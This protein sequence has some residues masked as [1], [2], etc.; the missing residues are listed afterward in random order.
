MPPLS[1]VATDPLSVG[2]VIK[3]RF[4][5]YELHE[6]I[7]KGGSGYV[8]RGVDCNTQMPV[9]V[10]VI[11]TTTQTVSTSSSGSNP[12]H[13]AKGGKMSKTIEKDC[14]EVCNGDES[15][16]LN[17][18]S[19]QLPGVSEVEALLRLQTDP[20][21]C[22]HI[23]QYLDHVSSTT[24][25]RRRVT[26]LGTGRS[27]GSSGRDRS[28]SDEIENNMDDGGKSGSRRNEAKDRRGSRGTIYTVSTTTFMI[29]EE[30]AAR[31]SL[32]KQLRLLQTMSGSSGITGNRLLCLRERDASRILYDV[33]RAL[34]YIHR[35]GILHRDIKA[36]NVLLCEDGTVKLSDFGLAIMTI[37]TPSSSGTTPTAS[38]HGDGQRSSTE[39]DRGGMRQ[40]SPTGTDT[41]EQS[42][43]VGG[44]G[45]GSGSSRDAGSSR[46]GPGPG[47]SHSS[48]SA[49]PSLPPGSLYWL[50]P[51]VL[52][53]ES[54]HTPAADVWS[55][56]CLCVEMLT[57][58]PPFYQYAPRHALYYIATLQKEQLPPLPV[59]WL[60][61]VRS[62]GG[63]CGPLGDGA[64]GHGAGVVPRKSGAAVAAGMWAKGGRGGSSR[65]HPSVPGGPNI[66]SASPV[67]STE[68]FDFLNACFQL[69][70]YDRPSAEALQHHPW[71][72]DARVQLKLNALLRKKYSGNIA[73]STLLSS[74]RANH[75]DRPNNQSFRG[76]DAERKKVDDRNGRPEPPD[77]EKPSSGEGGSNTDPAALEDDIGF[78]VESHLFSQGRL[79]AEEWLWEGY[80][81][82]TLAVLPLMTPEESFR[83]IHSYAYAAQRCETEESA[84][85]DHLGA[86]GSLSMDA[87]CSGDGTGGFALPAH[88]SREAGD[89]GGGAWD[90]K[91]DVSRGLISNSSNNHNTNERSGDEKSG[92]VYLA[93]V[94][95]HWEQG[96]SILCTVEDL[97]VLFEACCVSMDPRAPFFFPSQPR[98]LWYLLHQNRQSAPEVSWQCL[99][100][101]YRLLLSVDSKKKKRKAV[102]HT[103]Q[104]A[105][106]PTR[107]SIPDPESA[108]EEHWRSRKDAGG[109]SSTAAGA[110]EE[111]DED[112]DVFDD[113]DGDDH[114][115]VLYHVSP[116]MPQMVS[117]DVHHSPSSPKPA[118]TER[119]RR[120]LCRLRMVQDGG[121]LVLRSLLEE[122]CRLSFFHENNYHVYS[123]NTSGVMH[124]NASNSAYY[125]HRFHRRSRVE[126]E[127]DTTPRSTSSH[128]S[129][130]STSATP[131]SAAGRPPYRRP[132]PRSS[133]HG[134]RHG[135]HHK[136]SGGSGSGGV[137]GGGSLG[138]SGGV[139]GA[140]PYRPWREVDMLFEMIQAIAGDVKDTIPFIWGVKHHRSTSSARRTKPQ[141]EEE[142]GHMGGRRPRRGDE[143]VSHFQ[144][145]ASGVYNLRKT[146]EG[147]LRVSHVGVSSSDE[148]EVEHRDRHRAE[149]SGSSRF[150]SLY[151]EE[152]E[153]ERVE[154]GDE[155]GETSRESEPD[156]HH[157]GTRLFYSYEEE[158]HVEHSD[159]DEGGP[160]GTGRRH[161]RSRDVHASRQPRAPRNGKESHRRRRKHGKEEWLAAPCVHSYCNTTY[162]AE[163]PWFFALQ[164]A[165][166]HLCP[167]AIKLLLEYLARVVDAKGLAEQKI[168]H[169][170][171]NM[172]ELPSPSKSH[173][174]SN[175]TTGRREDSVT[176]S[177]S[178]PLHSISRASI[179]G[180]AALPPEEASEDR[181]GR[182]PFHLTS[183]PAYFF[184]VSPVTFTGTC[185]Y[186]AS[187]VSSPLTALEPNLPFFALQLLPWLQRKS[188]RAATY[189]REEKGSFS[190]LTTILRHYCRMP[191]PPVPP[192]L[193]S[194]HYLASILPGGNATDSSTTAASS[195]VWNSTAQMG[196]GGNSRRQSILTP[197]ASHVTGNLGVPTS[198][199]HGF[200]SSSPVPMG[201]AG[202]TTA[203][204]SGSRLHSSRGIS[205]SYFQQKW[206]WSIQV[207]KVLNV[208]WVLLQQDLRMAGTAAN[209]CPIFIDALAHIV[210]SVREEL[211][212]IERTGTNDV[213]K[214][215]W[216]ERDN[217][218]PDAH[219]K[220][221][222]MKSLEERV[223]AQHGAE[224]AAD[225]A[226]YQLQLTQLSSLLLRMI[227]LLQKQVWKPIPNPGNSNNYAS[228]RGPLSYGAHVHPSHDAPRPTSSFFPNP[229]VILN[230]SVS[231]QTSGV[232]GSVFQDS[233]TRLTLLLQEMQE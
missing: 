181:T 151:D 91:E 43:D 220:E 160:M 57:G 191:P 10:K 218:P 56:G 47:P 73:G 214:G 137:A 140:A 129:S 51:E 164:E 150:S 35:R 58:K 183:P 166:R 12:S 5:S 90:G 118:I 88:T 119:R 23:I 174:D 149:R 188:V 225:Y 70:P 33:T 122:H 217:F 209:H 135:A 113:E 80:V 233:G 72:M 130:E 36:A 232:S 202:S 199:P 48:T 182:T 75:S 69:N 226:S 108:S 136:P 206:Q 105:L 112:E 163:A 50:A 24:T 171:P 104:S 82:K 20:E 203:P 177:R 99:E 66:T 221:G 98:L 41:V 197:F 8:Y 124:V 115:D 19:L 158:D 190:L 21:H 3:G 200:F 185:L 210:H 132:S 213:G 114:E 131:Q 180:S 170:D 192:P 144:T 94:L 128:S 37:G 159:T 93:P 18:S 25:S 231:L 125:H 134:A 194:N 223:G 2:T 45:G 39:E 176:T 14:A 68:C 139:S 67:L 85:L 175:H 141:R 87:L 28:H 32:Q 62:S 6:I 172:L 153:E 84:F 11:I 17:S 147:L 95:F 123:I 111:T 92:Q 138:I 133:P 161:R 44:G 165:S 121:I 219:S 196:G 169:L 229:N 9:A 40:E 117:R 26:T 52:R 54:P 107:V 207:E 178:K 224:S 86:C 59:D 148:G 146:T 22:P 106:P 29:V 30:Y 179:W 16:T 101:L 212:K 7:G 145:S 38:M 100:A 79:H 228:L 152:S 46:V 195:D 65:P 64:G 78:W 230:S 211:R 116:D 156:R 15:E 4:S 89:L 142:A 96:L 42:G 34:A 222:G 143:T 184:N 189:L 81:Q 157:H 193:P 215:S 63:D 71:F 208:F 205:P 77:G 173:H 110:E 27:T 103:R 31:G 109:V 216:K 102:H 97:A 55:L 167:H 168:M 49:P 227:K 201:A 127:E 60:P 61:A 126:E 204:A 186:I 83:V 154:G 1:Y 53:G 74:A 155:G 187:C 120:H 198:A 76:M 13:S 162:T